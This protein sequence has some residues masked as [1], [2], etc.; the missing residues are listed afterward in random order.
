MDIINLF[1]EYFLDVFKK[2]IL[3][4]SIIELSL[5]FLSFF[6][7]IIIRTFFAKIIVFKIKKIV[8]KTGNKIDDHLFESLA[9]P[10]KILPIIFVFIFMGLFLETDS[11]LDIV[12][13]KINRTLI[14]KIVCCLLHQS[15]VPL[16]YLYNKLEELFQ[17][18]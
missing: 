1:K 13:E 17:K 12:L 2:G 9:P 18:H 15:I 5:I 14:T 6:I 10:L 3:G 4:L 8:H 11:Q 7:A 16:S